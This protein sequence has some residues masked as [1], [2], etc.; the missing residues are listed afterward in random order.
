MKLEQFGM[1]LKFLPFVNY[2]VH[3]NRKL[4]P[5]PFCYHFSTSKWFGGYQPIVATDKVHFL[6]LKLATSLSS[7]YYIL[8]IKASIV[9]LPL[10]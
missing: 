10:Q 2:R 7:W 4:C 5:C 3:F 1:K 6:T 8:H 9:F